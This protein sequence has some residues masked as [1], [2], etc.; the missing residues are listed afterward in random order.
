MSHTLNPQPPTHSTYRHSRHVH[1]KWNVC[2][3]PT[4]LWPS[5]HVQ[6]PL[7]SSL[8]SNSTLQ[9]EIKTKP[10]N[11]HNMIVF[12]SSGLFCFFF[13]SPQMSQ[14]TLIL[15]SAWNQMDPCQILSALRTLELNSTASKHFW[16]KIC[17]FQKSAKSFVLFFFSYLWKSDSALVCPSGAV[18][19]NIM[20]VKCWKTFRLE[21]ESITLPCFIAESKW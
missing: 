2:S 12:I 3:Y 4:Y 11:Y 19:H 13:K 10:S 20:A 16:E 5:G 7:W 21:G 15:L 8:P 6:L 17:D 1:W 14:L 9:A 18:Y